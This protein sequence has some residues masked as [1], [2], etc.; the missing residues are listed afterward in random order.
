MAQVQ[1]SVLTSIGD[2]QSICNICNCTSFYEEQYINCS[3]R[4]LPTVDTIP[5]NTA[6]L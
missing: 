1:E 5:A 2:G 6:E 3:F 4:H